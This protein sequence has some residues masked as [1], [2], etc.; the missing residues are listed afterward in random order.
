MHSLSKI[1]RWMARLH[2]GEAISTKSTNFIYALQLRLDQGGVR[3]LFFL[4]K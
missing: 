4:V 1:R 2:Y 3:V